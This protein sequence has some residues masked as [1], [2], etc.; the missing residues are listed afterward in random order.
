M[1]LVFMGPPG[2]GKGTQAKLLC[3]H[4]R[5]VHISTGD[6]IRERIRSGTPT[7]LKAKPFVESG[8]LVPDAVMV[9]MASERLGEPD[10]AA[11]FLLDGFPRTRAQAEALD[12]ALAAVG[13]RVEAV[14]LLEVAD[15][16]VVVR[17]SGRRTCSNSSCQQNYHVLT[18][19]PKVE[20]V[21][22]RCGHPL[23]Q[24]PDDRP[25]AIRRRLE[26]YHRQ[27]EEVAG[28]Y[29]AAGVVRRVSGVGLVDEVQRRIRESLG[30]QGS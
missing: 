17:L 27:T 6:M 25:D 30:D 22:D 20:N 21:C 14:V 29:A 9:D 23:F 4:Y 16:E 13:R 12:R 3:E 18:I 26:N 15:D 1:R 2:A 10:A 11:G 8:G 5:I 28:Y 19:R 7:G 24:R